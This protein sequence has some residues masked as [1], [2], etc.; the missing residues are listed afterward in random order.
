MF[1]LAPL[2]NEYQV[3]F[4]KRDC[5]KTFRKMMKTG[6]CSL[7]KQLDIYFFTETYIG[8]QETLYFCAD[9]LCKF[10]LANL[11]KESVYGKF[12]QK[13]IILERRLEM[14]E[15]ATTDES[16]RFLNENVT[17]MEK[18]CRKSVNTMARLKLQWTAE[19][20]LCD[21]HC[22]IGELTFEY[23]IKCFDCFTILHNNIQ[24]IVKQLIVEQLRASK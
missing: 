13:G 12:E 4:L 6:D 21:Y 18:S 5:V 11:M 9:F 15:K 8:C 16:V 22:L 19:A 24:L 10:S 14:I 17:K 2:A 7:E 3:A 20:K 23:I 1:I